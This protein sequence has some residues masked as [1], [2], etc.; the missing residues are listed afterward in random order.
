MDVE[1]TWNKLYDD[2][3]YKDDAPLKFAN[4]IIRKLK[5]E[6]TTSRG[7]YVGCGNGRN[8]I[9]M[10]DAGLDIMGLDISSTALYLLA[11]KA[12]QHF[13]M[14]Y[15]GNFLNYIPE[16]VRKFNYIISIQVFQHGSMHVIEKY[17]KKTA[18]LLVDDG[19]LFLRVNASNT[20]IKNEHKIIKDKGL[21][22]KYLEGGKKGLE[23]HF[24]TK[25]ELGNLLVKNGMEIIKIKN[26]T[27]K[28]KNQSK[29][30]Q[31]EITA[32]KKLK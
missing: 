8:F 4:H 17:F 12:P 20:T 18:S 22:V 28:R 5:K 25:D 15:K 21:T 29:W 6:K 31:W 19:L 10:S 9:K 24:F 27:I 23:I 7:L 30:A 2:G 14:L 16:H 26:V 13:H 1:K 3:K 32:V 11:K